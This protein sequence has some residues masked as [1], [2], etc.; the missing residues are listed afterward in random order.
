MS[1]KQEKR[2]VPRRADPDSDIAVESE[3]RGHD[4]ASVSF[5]FTLS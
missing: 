1:K 2:K 3:F 5:A 4:L